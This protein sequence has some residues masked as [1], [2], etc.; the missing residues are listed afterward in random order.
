[1]SKCL[2]T[3]TVSFKAML[4]LKSNLLFQL[5]LIVLWVLEVYTA[6]DAQ[7]QIKLLCR[8]EYHFKIM[9]II[10]Y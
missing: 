5:S 10:F 4:C 8:L 2:V 6:G 3:S 7:L 9:L 1:M